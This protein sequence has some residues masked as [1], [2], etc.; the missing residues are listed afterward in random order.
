M[1]NER[2]QMASWRSKL[3][4]KKTI[5][6]AQSLQTFKKKQDGHVCITRRFTAQL[7]QLTVQGIPPRLSIP[8]FFPFLVYVQPA[9]PDGP[10]DTMIG[11]MVPPSYSD[12]MSSGPMSLRMEGT[13]ISSAV[14]ARRRY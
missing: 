9:M 6:H 8:F 12:S 4:K 11:P 3:R 1:T 5:K 14:Q 2:D 10:R 7:A 13:A